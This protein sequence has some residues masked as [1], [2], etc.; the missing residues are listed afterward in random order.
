ME[1]SPHRKIIMRSTILQ[2][3]T[4]EPPILSVR[5]TTMANTTP[6]IPRS[7]LWTHDPSTNLRGE[8]VTLENMTYLTNAH[9]GT[10]ETMKNITNLRIK[11][12]LSVHMWSNVPSLHLIRGQSATMSALSSARKHPC[13]LID[14][15]VIEM[16]AK[17]NIEY[18]V[19]HPRFITKAE[20]L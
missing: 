17:S 3:T 6:E 8:S 5:H 4:T 15:P 14:D 11:I 13:M 2:V 19:I 18:D 10:H 1:T 12:A 7:F 16:R 20:N 9:I